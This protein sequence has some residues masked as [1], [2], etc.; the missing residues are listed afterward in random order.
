MPKKIPIFTTKQFLRACRKI[1]LIL[2]KKS[3]KGSHVKIINPKT[4]HSF[5]V[6]RKLPRGLQV[7]IVKKVESWGYDR[8]KFI[9]FFSVALLVFIKNFLKNLFS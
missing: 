4:N 1:G 8:E 2:N 6:P 7:A 9:K 5:P 3:G